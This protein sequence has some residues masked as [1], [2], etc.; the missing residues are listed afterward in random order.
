MS[1]KMLKQPVD[2][3]TGVTL[4][5]ARARST[6]RCRRL[7]NQHSPMSTCRYC[8][9]AYVKSLLSGFRNA[10][11]LAA[12]RVRRAR[13]CHCDNRHAERVA[14]FPRRKRPLSLRDLDEYGAT[15]DG[16]PAPRRRGGGVTSPEPSHGGTT[17]QVRYRKYNSRKISDFCGAALELGWRVSD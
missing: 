11:L 7:G 16:R 9:I 2:D 13:A 3:V 10:A 1:A 8:D 4:G 17:P 14:G 15:V 6:S 5:S 12:S